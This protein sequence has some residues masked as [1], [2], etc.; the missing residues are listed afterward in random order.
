MKKTKIKTIVN[1]DGEEIQIKYCKGCDIQIIIKS[2]M[3][4][5][6]DAL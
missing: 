3:I 6:I 2:N 5:K 1:N 4:P